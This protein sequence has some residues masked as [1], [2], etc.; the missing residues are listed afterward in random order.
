VNPAKSAVPAY[1]SRLVGG[2]PAVAPR[3]QPP[4]P[5]FPPAAGALTD[6]EPEPPVARFDGHA[7]PRQPDAGLSHHRGPVTTS[8]DAAIAAVPVGYQASQGLS[9][10]QAAD[11][12]AVDPLPALPAE[13]VRG[14]MPPVPRVVQHADL[15]EA[16]MSSAP[17]SMPAASAEPAAISVP[18]TRPPPL[19]G[20]PALRPPKP[21]SSVP[22]ISDYSGL[23]RP[24]AVN[25]PTTSA[26]VSIGTIEVTVLPAKPAR[27][28]PKPS[29]QQARPKEVGIP[30]RVGADAARLAAR[31]AARRWF[32]AGQS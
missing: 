8:S 16:T 18:T 28:L 2:A 1:L 23:R 4:R 12:E 7:G 25:A 24:T 9:R 15:I 21:G 31:G 29:H 11:G 5:L 10:A 6:A 30:A 19:A 13:P 26:Q 17:A 14:A 27:I 32:G 22:E 3:L 20:V